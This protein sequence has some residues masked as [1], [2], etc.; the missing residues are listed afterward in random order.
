VSAKLTIKIEP[1][2]FDLDAIFAEVE[3]LAE[4]E[5]WAAGLTFRVNLAL[6]ELTLNTMTHGR[7]DELEAIEVIL[8]SEE[9]ALTIEITDNGLPFNP[10]EDAPDP[11]VDGS[12]QDR[13]VGGLG[14]YLV[15]T[16]MDEMQYKRAEGRNC[17]TLKARRAE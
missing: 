3:T 4:R 12:L 13:D 10:L 17:L 15:H 1:D 5:E 6:E 2:N 9:D 16:L 11:S 14:V 8:D 7:H